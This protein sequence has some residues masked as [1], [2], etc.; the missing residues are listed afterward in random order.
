MNVPTRTLLVTNILNDEILD[1][2]MTNYLSGYDIREVYSIKDPSTV[3]FIL[4]YDIKS[5]IDA[6]KKLKNLKI[7][8]KNKESPR[9]I[10]DQL[11][12]KLNDQASNKLNDEILIKAYF[13][14]SK[15]EIPREADKCDEYKNQGTLLLMMRDMKQPLTLSELK[16]NLCFD[17]IRDYK[18]FQKYLEFN[19]SRMCSKCVEMYHNF[20]INGGR[21]W[22]KYQWDHPANVRFE[23]MN[24]IEKILNGL[25]I[26]NSDVKNDKC[27]FSNAFDEFIF[28]NIDEIENFVINDDYEL[29]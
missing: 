14:I 24:F 27:V 8:F 3:R 12:T 9:I 16:E 26:T 28:E 1:E 5:S 18:P 13:A 4:F 19:D 25:K 21:I 22:L 20:E 15:Y 7:N 29:E 10:N 23:I 11:I 6:Q 17:N 2:L